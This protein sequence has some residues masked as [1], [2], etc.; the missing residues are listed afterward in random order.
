[1]SKIAY[2]PTL[3]WWMIPAAITLFMA[4]KI[5]KA[6]R[7]AKIRKGTELFNIWVPELDSLFWAVFGWFSIVVSWLVYFIA[8]FFLN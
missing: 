3:D 1:M 5:F 6:N 4:V 8:Y 7:D 2:I